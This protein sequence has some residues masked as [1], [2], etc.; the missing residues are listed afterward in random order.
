[1]GP[2]LRLA[3]A[4][5]GLL[6]RP[7]SAFAAEPEPVRFT[8][9]APAGCPSEDAFLDAVARDGG[10]LDRAGAQ[11]SVRSFTVTLTPGTPSVGRLEVKGLDGHEA[12]RTIEGG[13]C[14]DVARSLCW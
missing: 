13:R 12:T 6:L 1:M 2:R 5:A 9:D 10:M 8:Y 3:L 4:V 7:T 11:A 14:E